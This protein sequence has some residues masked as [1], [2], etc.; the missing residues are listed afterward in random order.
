MT[1][2]LPSLTAT[3]ESDIRYSAIAVAGLRKSYASH[4]RTWKCSKA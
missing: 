1:E 2:T 3:T 4:S